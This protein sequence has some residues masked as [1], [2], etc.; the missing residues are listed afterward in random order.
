VKLTKLRHNLYRWTA[1]H[2]DYEPDPEQDSPADWPE[3]V[4]C[5]AYEAAEALVL[6]DPLVPEEL[7]PALDRLADKAP[8]AVPP[9]GSRA[10]PAI[11]LNRPVD[12]SGSHAKAAR[13]RVAVLTTIGFHRRSRDAVAERY[14]ASTSRAKKTLPHGVETIRI[15]RAGETMVWIPEHAALVPGDR[16]LG[17]HDGGLRVC[18]DS[19]LRYLPSGI[20]GEELREALRPLLQLPIELVLVSHG[21]PVLER[22]HAALERA[23]RN[24]S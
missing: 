6:I 8:L 14:G 20:T 1:P 5:V 10:S 24:I 22:G 9:S 3:Q 21:E 18:P 16:I 19:W 15:P 4:G 17:G 7:W 12:R 11:R 23:L 13:R 2:P